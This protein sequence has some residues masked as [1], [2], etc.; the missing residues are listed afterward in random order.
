[1]SPKFLI[2]SSEQHLL[3]SPPGTRVCITH[4]RSNINDALT[5]QTFD[6]YSLIEQSLIIDD[7]TIKE[8]QC[9]IAKLNICYINPRSQ[10]AMVREM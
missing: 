3:D 5:R 10:N 8:Y 2:Y 4:V 7:C 9:T 6:Q 1:M